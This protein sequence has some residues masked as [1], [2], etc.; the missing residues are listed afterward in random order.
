MRSALICATSFLLIHS[1]MADHS[2][3]I[4][5][6]TVQAYP[7]VSQISTVS[8][9]E[10][11]A[12]PDSAE[13]LRAIPGANFNSNGAIT[14]IA[15][16]RGLFGDRVAV[17]LDSSPA[18]TGGPNAMDTPLSYAPA[19]LL[20]EL[21]VHR[22]IAP[23]SAAQESLGGHV[24]AHFDRGNFNNGRRMQLDGFVNSR[25]GDNGDQSASNLQLVAANKQHKVALLAAYD[26]GNNSEAGN[27]LQ[28]TGTQ[29]QRS[30]T[31]LSYGL[32]SGVTNADFHIGQLDISNTGTPALAMDITSVETDLAGFNLSTEIDDIKVFADLAWADVVHSMDNHSLRQPP[33]MAM[34][35]RTNLATADNL[36]WTLKAV[37]PINQASLTLG[38]DGNLADHNS[39]I[40]NPENSMFNLVNFNQVERDSLGIFAELEGKLANSWN[41]EAGLRFNQIDLLAGDVSAAGM[42]GMMGSNAN[43]LAA[44]FNAQDR[45][46][47]HNNTDLVIKL[48]RALNVS[49]SFNVDLGIK[50]RAP[51]YQELFLWLPLPITAGL[52]DGRS[53]IGNTQLN[54]ETAKEIN[55]AIS[56]NSGNFSIAPQIFYRRIDDYIQGTTTMNMTANM[57]S[58]MMS[59]APALMHNNV[60]AEIYGLDASWNYSINNNWSVDGLFSY[61]RGKRTDIVD[62][63]YRIAPANNRISLHYRPASLEQKLQL[64]IESQIYARQSKVASFNGESE[65]AGYGII[66]LAGQWSVSKHLQIQAG[67]ANLFDRLVINHLSGRN[68]AMGSDIALGAGIPDSG[69]NLYIALQVKW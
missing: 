9:T 35:Y 23:V 2:H 34:D 6:I 47:S 31:D 16:Y 21:S 45:D 26:E 24:S 50:H 29:Y 14:G 65:T 17:S 38:T 10:L 15:Q 46:V 19:S 48:S 27:N 68:R 63:L 28:L 62:N 53:Y 56:H 7:P 43:I 5:E 49:T 66:N 32:Q 59:G 55:L 64:S 37:L 61:V 54:S 30:R 36:S 41:Y 44:A 51:S 20:K 8:N 1:T 42:M 58:N 13:L 11:F 67:V 52:A 60:D 39:V 12:K 57:V 25:Y 18:L 4:N 40:S 69:R 3:N 22:G 33:M